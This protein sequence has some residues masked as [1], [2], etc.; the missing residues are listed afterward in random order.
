MIIPPLNF[1]CITSLAKTPTPNSVEWG[2]IEI[3]E[4]THP[5]DGHT[6]LSYKITIFEDDVETTT[7]EVSKKRFDEIFKDQI[8]WVGDKIFLDSSNLE[9]C[10]RIGKQRLEIGFLWNKVVIY[11]GIDDF[12]YDELVETD[13]PGNYYL[14]NIKGRYRYEVLKE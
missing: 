7:I 4:K 3:I 2:Q 11:K 9:Y 6:Y 12:I 5:T 13:H 1:D 8:P 14:N 10:R